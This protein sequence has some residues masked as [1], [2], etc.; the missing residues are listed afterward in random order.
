MAT[1]GAER[2]FSS[3][4]TVVGQ[5]PPIWP[6]NTRPWRSAAN[7]FPSQG[8][9][10]LSESAPEC[11]STLTKRPKE[12]VS[13]SLEAFQLKLI[14][15]GQINCASPLWERAPWCTPSGFIILGKQGEYHTS[16]RLFALHGLPAE[17][18]RDRFTYFICWRFL[19]RL[20]SFS[21]VILHVDGTMW[22]QPFRQNSGALLWKVL[23]VPQ[24]W[25]ISTLI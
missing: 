8:Q 3:V 10:W 9:S 24:Q 13:T 21:G 23:P 2:C 4:W 7:E 17:R 16:W 25:V 18:P 11:W 6:P 1:K 19:K 12:E 20:E 14:G 5:Y 15:S 22:S